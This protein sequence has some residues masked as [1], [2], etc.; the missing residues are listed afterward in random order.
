MKIKFFTQDTYLLPWLDEVD[1]AELKIGTFN[2]EYPFFAS[3]THN[4]EICEH[5]KDYLYMWIPGSGSCAVVLGEVV[6]TGHQ[7]GLVKSRK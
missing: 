2:E 3:Y 4:T 5:G 6:D 7:R 1:E